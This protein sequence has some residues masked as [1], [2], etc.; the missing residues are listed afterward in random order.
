[1]ELAIAG[2][3]DAGAL[4]F[5][6]NRELLNSSE[7]VGIFSS[8]RVDVVIVIT[9][10]RLTIDIE[11]RMISPRSI[12]HYLPEANKINVASQLITMITISYFSF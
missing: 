2:E 4:F 10:I 8:P 1:M 6:F 7:G 3:I 12:F 11:A 9:I 5:I